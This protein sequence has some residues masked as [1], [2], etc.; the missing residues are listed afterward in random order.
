MTSP[1]HVLEGERRL[2]QSLLWGLQRRFYA[3]RGPQA[4]LEDKLPWYVTSNAFTA[5]G[6][7]RAALGF[8]RDCRS[9]RLGPLDPSRPIDIVELAAGPGHFG[10]LFLKKLLDLKGALPDLAGLRVR[11][12]MTDLAPAN[13]EAWRRSVPLRPHVER[14]EMDFAVFDAE[15]GGEIALVGSGEVL[16]PGASG[17]P[18]LVIANYL[19]DS[20]PQDLFWI[21]EG[22]LL[23]GAVSL[24]SDRPEDPALSDPGLLARL[25]VRYQPRPADLPYYDDPAI[26]RIL[27]SYRSRL[28]NGALLFPVGALAVLRNAL[29]LFGPRLLLLAADKGGAEESEILGKG[30]PRLTVHGGCFSLAVNFDALAL[31]VKEAGG[32]VLRTPSRDG[33][34]RVF[35][36]LNGGAEDAFAET[37]LAF[38]EALGRFSPLDYFTLSHHLRSSEPAPPLE[39]IL[40]LL[41]LGEGDSRLIVSLADAI[42]EQAA[43]APDPVRRDL[44]RELEVAAAHFYPMAE[45]LPFELG[46]IA[47]RMG[48]PLD[49]LRCFVESLR[50]FGRS[51][52]TLFN[53]GLCLYKLQQPAEAL[54]LMEAALAL[55]P[56]FGAAREWRDRIR[57]GPGGAAGD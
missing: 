39:T 47:A 53:A 23:E 16:R 6:Y 38:A 25:D 2:S 35:A 21:R 36:S 13:L 51:P 48:W 10:Y 19:F 4:W 34:L 3:D 32:L 8:L 46:R 5:A 56:G 42:A 29:R 27:E 57:K 28:G 50:L 22:R 31:Y 11:Y 33:R 43:S 45:D 20:L 26:D 14:G 55:S 30:A 49:A 1:S 15:R 9:G 54:R 7:A 24:H 12:V 17:N 52:A 18:A 37:R 44:V 40:A 41:R